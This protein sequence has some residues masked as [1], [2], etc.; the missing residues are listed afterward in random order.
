[1]KYLPKKLWHQIEEIAA[2]SEGPNFVKGVAR[3]YYDVCMLEL[4]MQLFEPS[5]DSDVNMSRLRKFDPLLEKAGN[6]VLAFDHAYLGFNE[7]GFYHYRKTGAYET[8][9][10]LRLKWVQ[11]DYVKDLKRYYQGNANLDCGFYN[12]EVLI[13]T[14][15]AGLHGKPKNLD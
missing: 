8:K 10:P 9:C 6:A 4:K 13:D 2:E 3:Q 7:P 15:I 5:E 11:D 1:M 14:Y 12:S